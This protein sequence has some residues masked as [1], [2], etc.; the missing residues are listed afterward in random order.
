MVSRLRNKLG[1][2]CERGTKADSQVLS[3]WYLK[4]VDAIIINKA[5]SFSV[6]YTFIFWIC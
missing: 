5:I 3:L 2:E 1:V 6:D 4:N